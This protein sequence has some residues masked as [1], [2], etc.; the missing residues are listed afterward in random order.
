MSAGSKLPR[1]NLNSVYASFDAPEYIRDKELLAEHANKLLIQLE[2]PWPEDASQ[3]A[4][5]ILSW[6]H[7]YEDTADLAENL[8]AYASAV[9][10]TDT[11][12]SRALNEINSLEALSLPLGKASVILRSRLAEQAELVQNLAEKDENLVEY[13]FFLKDALTRAKYQMAPELEDLANDL[14]RSG[15]DAWSRLQEAISSTVSAEWDPA[16]GEKKTVIALRDLAH[17][18]D[19]SIRE[20]AYRAELAAWESMKIPLAASLNGVKGFAIT[21]DKRR[22]WQSALDK[23]AYQSRITRK[24]LDALISVMEGSLPLFRRYLKAKSR[25]LAIERCAFY[26]L[27]AP[28]GRATKKWSWEESRD[29]IIDKFSAF[30]PA[31]GNF[32][33]HAFTFSWIDA[34]GREG[35]IG[36]A[37]CTDF[38]LAKESRIL[39]NFEGSFDSVTT[40]AHE[41]GHAW[42]HEVI[43]DLPSTLT[44]YPMTLAETA[45]TFAETIILEGALKTADTQERLSLIE[46][47]L[48]DACQIIVDILSRF[49]FERSV[50]ER[51]EQGELSAEEFCILMKEAQVATYGDGLDAGLL[52]PYM[53]AVKSHYYSTGLAFYN[54]PY[55]FGQLF[56]L[57]LYSR[58]R[59][60]GSAFAGTYK[61]ILRLTGRASAEDVGRAAGFNLEGPEFWQNGINLIAERVTELE[62]LIHR[63]EEGK[64]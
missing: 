36:G 16:T 30:D 22:G 43:K 3:A 26:D 52:H 44:A 14:A 7:S 48:K 12:N 8:E 39:C 18:P 5:L 19:R 31:M 25:I 6:I 38:P 51:R 54:F 63:L 28:V 58:A 15:G 61:E 49:Y 29:F 60:Q 64:K 47:S 23:A 40:V 35:K 32:A 46:G 11:R 37:Y 4:R 20:R 1:W 9:Y 55:A 56:A 10:T 24:T 53:W 2:Q 13:R 34:E 42:H 17:D 45:S 33:R 41:L 59:E 27:F 62:T 21:V 57:G 50:F